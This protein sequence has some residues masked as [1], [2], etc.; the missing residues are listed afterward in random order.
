M[1]VHALG[2]E[3]WISVREVWGEDIFYI[4]PCSRSSL[5]LSPPSTPPS[6]P[7]QS[8]HRSHLSR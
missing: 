3:V 1:Q 2:E 5:L 8:P 7:L 4:P 6:T